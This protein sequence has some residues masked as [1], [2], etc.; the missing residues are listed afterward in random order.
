[1]ALKYDDFMIIVCIHVSENSHQ[2]MNYDV[3]YDDRISW[4][5]DK[6]PNVIKMCQNV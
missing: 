1:M 2:I 3:F 4:Y 5:M 6:C